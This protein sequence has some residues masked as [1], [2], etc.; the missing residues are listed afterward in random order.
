[1]KENDKIDATP[2]KVG[3]T[4]RSSKKVN[5]VILSDCVDRVLGIICAFTGVIFIT[6][7]VA[8]L[9]PSMAPTI[10]DFFKKLF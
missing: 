9:I 2:K 6:A 5:T 7:V 1:M 10:V 3:M 4:N 8:T